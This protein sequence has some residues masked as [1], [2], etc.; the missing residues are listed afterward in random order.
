MKKFL[1]LALSAIFCL[2]LCACGGGSGYVT[3]DLVDKTANHQTWLRHPESKLVLNPDAYTS[4]AEVDASKA[5]LNVGILAD[6]ADGASVSTVLNNVLFFTESNMSNGKGGEQVWKAQFSGNDQNFP[7]KEKQ[8]LVN[9][10]TPDSATISKQESFTLKDII[11][12]SFKGIPP[13][14]F[15]KNN[16]LMVEVGA[17]EGGRAVFQ[18]EALTSILNANAVGSYSVP[19]NDITPAGAA[20]SFGA[21][22]DEEYDFML[23]LDIYKGGSI[24]LNSVQIRQVDPGYHF[25]SQ[26]AR[27]FA[28]Y[29]LNYNV[30]FPQDANITVSDMLLDA[31]TVVRKVT[32]VTTGDLA[33][34]GQYEGTATYNMTKGYLEVDNNGTKYLIFTKKKADFAWYN[35]EADLLAKTNAVA[36][37]EQGTSGYWSLGLG[38]LKEGDEFYLIFTVGDNFDDMEENAKK[39]AQSK[40]AGELQTTLTEYWDLWLSENKLSDGFFVNEPA[41]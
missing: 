9:S 21:R 24:T 17:V 6:T 26:V 25:A 7:Y 3:E 32:V 36:D 27:S 15:T 2:G 35:N 29:A 41:K 16:I 19:L 22:A 23:Q 18:T 37:G 31:S 14:N 30:V 33:M 8:L 40:I 20:E 12:T 34:G 11:Q 39:S 28:P 5:A 38:T 1:A 4:G 13:L 10:A